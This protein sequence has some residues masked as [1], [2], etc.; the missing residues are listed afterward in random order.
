VKTK[1]P[2]HFGQHAGAVVDNYAHPGRTAI[3]S[4]PPAEVKPVT[5]SGTTQSLAMYG[6]DFYG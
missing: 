5:F 6:M 3:A 2:G 1:N 4:L